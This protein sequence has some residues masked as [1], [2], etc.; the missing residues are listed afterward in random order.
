MRAVYYRRQ[1]AAAEV[2]ELGDLPKPVPARGEVLVRIEVSGINPSDIKNRSG[3]AFKMPFP[4]IVPHQDGAGVV[5][6]VGEGVS[7]SRVGERVWIFEAQTGRA[8]G[9]AAEYVAVPSDNAVPL[10][11]ETSFEIGASLGV[12]AMTAHRCLFAG[13]E[14][15]GRRVLVQ[16]GAGAVGSGAIQLA[17]WAG[18]WVA[19]T[20][21]RPG[22][23][24]VARAAGADLVIDLAADSV[25]TEITSHT[26]GE[27]VDR[28]V[29]VDLSANL[30]VDLKC[31]ASGGSISA[32]STHNPKESILLPTMPAMLGNAAVRF[33]Y[34]YTMP[35]SAKRMAIR[36]I[37]E[38]LLTKVYNPKIG[39][40]LP[41]RRTVEGHLAVESGTIGKTLIRL[42]A[43]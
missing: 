5:E 28:I 27:G 23:L 33:V 42:D 2:L 38:C 35:T 13:G 31:L 10:P 25:E 30:D 41:L 6:D 12:P 24:E 9:T 26:R 22:Q 36:E 21:R 18:A 16:G 17:K 29:E 14:L 20:V 4:L 43:E 11:D 32:Y 34:V 1:G 15:R 7:R 3:F 19:A 39:L 8:R 37:S 40:I